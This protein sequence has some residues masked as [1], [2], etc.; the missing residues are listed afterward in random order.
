MAVH[1][2]VDFPFYVPL[3]LLL[4]GALL[5]ALD[6]RLCPAAPRSQVAGGSGP[7]LRA[8]R[9]G[10]ATIASLV[11]LRPVVAEAASAWGS[12]AWAAGQGQ[13][14]AFWLGIAQRVDAR[15]W[16]YH[17]QAGQFWD[18]QAVESGKR[19]AAQLAVDAYQAGLTANPLEVKNLLGLIAAHRRHR[20]LLA[21][22]ADE[23][24]LRA[25][26]ARALVLAPLHP[27]VRGLAFR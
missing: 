8:V 23:K 9:A 10:V 18:A 21:S 22:A 19:E 5:G 15:D 7:S 1:A 14:A 27:G 12:Q 26:A 20:E 3:C 4:Y 25:W 2:L 6:R 24:T 13:V 17:W 16:R 11:L